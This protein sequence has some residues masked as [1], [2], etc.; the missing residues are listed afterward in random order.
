MSVLK[1]D[2]SARFY[3]SKSRVLTE[4]LATRLGY[5]IVSR[6]LSLESFPAISAEE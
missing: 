1:I 5:P 2:S 6:D 4:Y 3:D